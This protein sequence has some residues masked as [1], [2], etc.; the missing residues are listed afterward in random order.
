MKS[1]LSISF[2]LLSIVGL[3]TTSPLHAKSANQE[4]GAKIIRSLSGCFLVDYNYHETESLKEGYSVDKRTYDVN[5]KNST[6]KEWIEAID[7]KNG[8]IRL[9]HILFSTDNT[10]KPSSFL[11]HQP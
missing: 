8:V 7:R 10:G 2:S 5:S 3:F 11:K 1:F 6:V 4:E 9:Q